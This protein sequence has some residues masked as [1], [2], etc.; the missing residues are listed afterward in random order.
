[1]EL[2][3]LRYFLAVAQEQNIT[4][5]AE[6]LY[7]TQPSLSKQ[8]QNLEREVGRP[9][10]VRGN[11]KLLL[12]DTGMLLK[13]RAEELLALYE[14]TQEEISVP[15]EEMRGEV[16]IGCGESYAV[17]TVAHAAKRT[18]G[19]YAGI[20]F[21]FFSGDASDVVEKLDK[22]LIDFGVLLDYVNVA[23]YNSLRLPLRDTWG[24]LMRKDSPLAAKEYIRS[25]DLR[26]VPLLCSKQSLS[27]GRRVFDWF[28]ADVEKLDL[29]AVYNL[30]YNASLLVREGMGYALCL[31]KLIN[32]SGESDLC[33][34][35]LFPK[36][37]THLD[38]VWK[39]YSV[40]SK[41]AEI[42]L[43]VLRECV[44]EQ[45]KLYGANGFEMP[46]MPVTNP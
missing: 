39:K 35:P 28:G 16:F 5:A 26:R 17:Q 29:R 36:V 31:E 8:M 4:K 22:G 24:V 25:E 2:R 43:N 7:I 15:L 38:V 32:T 20:R 45:E 42:F 34:R 23:Q 10:F 37:E 21:N 1:M 30:V 11:R 40:F 19:Q 14:K 6:Q 3:E 44:E 12:T 18:Q 27:K 13:K 41:P 46:P 9:L 33:F